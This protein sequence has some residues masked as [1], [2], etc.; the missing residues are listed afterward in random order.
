MDEQFKKLF[1]IVLALLVGV[2]IILFA[3]KGSSLFSTNVSNDTT[4]NMWKDALQVIPQWSSSKTL[5][6]KQSGAKSEASTTTTDTLARNLLV[7]YA[8]VQRNM[9]TTTLSDTD[10]QALAQ[11]LINKIEV[12]HGATYSLKDLVVSSDNSD[13]AFTAYSKKVSDVMRSFTSAHT[14]SEL[15]LVAEALSTQDAKKLGG[16]GPIA[17]QYASLNKNLLAIKTPSAVAPMHLR[18]VQSY[19][20][21]EA[22]I[23]AMQK[24]FTDPVQGLVALTQYKKEVI[25][26]EVLAG[27]YKN[28]TPTR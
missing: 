7:D 15:A 8:M 19:A 17:L 10:A 6:L 22:T 12:P 1:S 13:A 4:S 11:M 16:L 28:Y 23:I 18:L 9:S 25:A 27:D 14:A 26:L 2:G 24:M 20:N 21:I 5:G 3:W